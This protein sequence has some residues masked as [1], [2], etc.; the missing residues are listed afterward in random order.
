MNSSEREPTPSLLVHAPLP[1]NAP[2]LS[3]GKFHV[4][5]GTHPFRKPQS[6]S[7][8]AAESA[9]HDLHPQASLR[10]CSS[11]KERNTSVNG[12]RTLPIR[13]RAHS[14]PP[15]RSLP[16]V[17]GP[18]PRSRPVPR[19]PGRRKQEWT[20]CAPHRVNATPTASRLRA[21]TRRLSARP[22]R[23]AI[24]RASGKRGR[25]VGVLATK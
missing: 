8:R 17:T 9:P 19:G 7:T 18:P 24:R 5:S 11:V 21:S 25:G 23:R 12:L 2:S 16:Q 15:G 1:G 14:A 4:T 22:R 13:E 20:I 3:Q 6:L 10:P